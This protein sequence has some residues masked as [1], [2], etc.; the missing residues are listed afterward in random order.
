MAGLF[1]RRK[2]GS[3]DGACDAAAIY[4]KNRVTRGWHAAE[5]YPNSTPIREDE[6]AG[7]RD[8]LLPILTTAPPNIRQQFIPLL[9]KILQHDFPEKWPNFM[10]ITMQLLGAHDAPSVFA[11]L[12]CLLAIC[13]VYRF[14]ATETRG[15]F[16]KIVA[17]AFPSV[18]RIGVNLV[19]ETSNDAGEMLRVVMK[20][21][22]HA[23]FV[24][25]RLRCT[26]LSHGLI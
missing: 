8:R 11:G 1:F 19:S 26:S 16:D 3:A 12:Q 9:Q 7:F 17:L 22:K 25:T 6:K 14:K 4:L 2:S 15:D 20:C 21:F 24:R 23:T 10:D 18:L 5:E 13:R